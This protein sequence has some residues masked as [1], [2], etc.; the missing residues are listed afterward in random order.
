MSL[1]VTV[2]EIERMSGM[3][4]QV[5]IMERTILQGFSKNQSFTIIA[6]F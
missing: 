6:P 3:V 5:S 1:F 2:A 4:R